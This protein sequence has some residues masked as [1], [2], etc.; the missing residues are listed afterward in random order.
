MRS[1]SSRNTGIRFVSATMPV[2]EDATGR[3]LEGNIAVI[4]ELYSELIADCPAFEK[5]LAYSFASVAISAA[6]SA[7]EKTRTSSMLPLVRQ[8][9]MIGSFPWYIDGDGA[10][11]LTET[12]LM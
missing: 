7:R 4:N 10:A 3:L 11:L 12:P 9:I 5:T 8:P 2:T 6:E 1:R